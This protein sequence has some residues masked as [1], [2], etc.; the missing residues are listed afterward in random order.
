MFSILIKSE[1]LSIVHRDIK[2][3][4]ILVEPEGNFRLIDLRISRHLDLESITSSNAPIGPHTL[5][6]SASE[7]FRNRKIDIDIRA[8]FFSLGVVAAEMINSKNRRSRYGIIL[9]TILP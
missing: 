7:Q 6:Y 1:E 5:G 9:I 8:D 4:N 2:P 3:E